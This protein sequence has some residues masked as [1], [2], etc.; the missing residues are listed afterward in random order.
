MQKDV[1]RVGRY[2]EV[3]S[4][5]DRAVSARVVDRGA[6]IDIRFHA[7]GGHVRPGLRTGVVEAVFE[8]PQVRRGHRLL[9]TVPV[10]D[11]ELMD[12]LRAHCTTMQ[13]RCAGATCLV[14]AELD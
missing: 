11:V 8:L 5:A 12:Q 1:V 10:G 6:V 2:T 13:V 9:A 4:G 14:D 3:Y 7:R